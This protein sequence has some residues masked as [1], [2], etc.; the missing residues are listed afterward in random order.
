M[1]KFLVLILVLLLSIALTACKDENKDKDDGFNHIVDGNTHG[2]YCDVYMPN[3]KD[4]VRDGMLRMNSY[5]DEINIEI[6]N[7]GQDRQFAIQV[8]VDYVQVQIK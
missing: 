7:A 5:V 6:E 4:S 3:A 2:Y 8:L 1:K